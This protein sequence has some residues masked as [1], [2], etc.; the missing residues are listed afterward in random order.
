MMYI[1]FVLIHSL[2]MLIHVNLVYALVTMILLHDVFSVNLSV[3][4]VSKRSIQQC[5]SFHCG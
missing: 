3:Y 1:L 4:A 2:Y 5:P